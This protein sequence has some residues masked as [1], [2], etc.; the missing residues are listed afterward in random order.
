[1]IFALGCEEQ[2]GDLFKERGRRKRKQQLFL[3]DKDCKRVRYNFL[4]KCMELR[5]EEKIEV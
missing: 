3:L 1:M 5:L 4:G 2:V